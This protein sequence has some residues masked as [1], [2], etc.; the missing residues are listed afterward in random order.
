[1]SDIK[2][3]NSGDDW[4][5]ILMPII[6]SVVISLTIV[7]GLTNLGGQSNNKDI[8]SV[9]SKIMVFSLADWMTQLPA[10]ATEEEMTKHFTKARIAAKQ[11]GE[12]GYIVVDVNYLLGF[13]ES[14]RLKP[15]SELVLQAD[16]NTGE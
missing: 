2:E 14:L 8:T 15:D 6:I 10:S 1:M 13:P 9:P 7:F 5:S 4:V 11:A 3:K 16:F 12:K